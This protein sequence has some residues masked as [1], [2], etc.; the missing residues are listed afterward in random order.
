[1]KQSI[2]DARLIQGLKNSSVAEGEYFTC[3]ECG[4][5]HKADEGGWEVAGPCKEGESIPVFCAVYCSDCQVVVRG[6]LERMGAKQFWSVD[7]NVAWTRIK[8][9]LKVKA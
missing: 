9:S 5:T 3:K 7:G 2:I 4:K 6:K 8:N 1:M